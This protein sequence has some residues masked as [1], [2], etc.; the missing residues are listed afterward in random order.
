MPPKV[1]A[2]ALEVLAWNTTGQT[3]WPCVDCGLMTGNF[4]DGGPLLNFQ[5]ICFACNRV[6]TEF[7]FGSTQRTPL[8]SYCETS[9][10]WCRFCRGIESC[11]PPGTRVHWSKKLGLPDIPAGRDFTREVEEDLYEEYFE[12]R[13]EEEQK[14]KSSESAP[15][16][17]YY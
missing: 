7:P 15:A 14:K 17:G 13:A 9:K 8:C 5:D 1:G 6:P 16:K 11:T 4:C 10:R 3:A 2:H 12:M